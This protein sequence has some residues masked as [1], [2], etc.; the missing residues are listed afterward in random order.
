MRQKKTRPQDP[1]DPVEPM[2]D[3][4]QDPV[5]Q[6]G[7]ASSSTGLNVKT[8]KSSRNR[9]DEERGQ[10]GRRVSFREGSDLEEVVELKEEDDDGRTKVWWWVDDV[11]EGFAEV[12]KVTIGGVHTCTSQTQRTVY[13]VKE[14]VVQCIDQF[15]P[16]RRDST[17]TSQEPAP[18]S[19]AHDDPDASEVEHAAQ[20]K[21]SS[22]SLRGRSKRRQHGVN[23]LRS[24]KSPCAGILSSPGDGPPSGALSSPGALSSLGGGSPS[25][26]CEGPASGAPSSPGAPSSLGADPAASPCGA[27][28]PGSGDAQYALGPHGESW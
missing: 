16:P 9:R 22:E 27:A 25:S 1:Q 8:S 3:N 14:R 24:P 5:H 15:G 20:E 18:M 11:L 4:P 19:F 26:P 10:A 12:Y 17:P 28:A 23:T 2:V 6:E 13:P 21:Q 7:S